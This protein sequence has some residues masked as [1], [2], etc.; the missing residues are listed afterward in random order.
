MSLKRK[1]KDT[2]KYNKL[3]GGVYSFLKEKKDDRALQ[4]MV[5]FT[6]QF[7]NRSQNAEKLCIVLAGYKEFAFAAVFGR[8]KRYIPDDIDVC[9][10]SSGLFSEKLDKMCEENGWS[11][12][13]TNENNVALVQNAAIYNH[14]NAR[15]IFKLDEDIFVTEHYFENMLRAYHH[16]QQGEYIPGVMAPLLPI[17]GY[18]HMRILEKLGLK[19]V[20]AEKFETPKY[21]AGADRK[22]ETD[23]Q[24]AKFFWGEGGYVPTIDEMNARFSAEPLE[25]RACPIRFSIGAILFE[26]QLWEDMRYFPVDRRTTN[27][28]KDEADLCSFCLINSRPLMVS[29]NVVAG[30]LSFG[31]QN[32]V[33]KQYF[34]EHEEM[35]L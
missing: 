1:L 7:K 26:R 33:M 2:L 13:S 23:P 18:A 21:K 12:L 29:E 28:G 15:Y 31:T 16:A 32:A 9:V 4:Y 19:E 5:G 24:V 20:F 27:M 30:H 3:T 34:H 11:Y 25:E 6:G 17:N 14:P 35:F 8:I 10:V 22:V